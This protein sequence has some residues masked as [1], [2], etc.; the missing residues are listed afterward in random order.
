MSGLYMMATISDRNQ[1]RRFL[2]FY[3]EYGLSVTLLPFY[4]PTAVREKLKLLLSSDA[5]DGNDERDPASRYI[6]LDLA[7]QPGL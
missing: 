3:R 7:F 5:A 6:D 2:D 1:A 4:E